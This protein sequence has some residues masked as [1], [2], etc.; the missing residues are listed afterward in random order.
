MTEEAAGLA[1]LHT[2]ELHRDNFERLVRERSN[3][4]RPLHRVEPALLA[5]AE[6]EG[7]EAPSVVA[8]TRQVVEAL[9]RQG[10]EL[11]VCTCSTLGAVVEALPPM[12]PCRTMR[13]DRPMAERATA[14][15]GRVLV[16]AAVASTRTPT[17]ALLADAA[18][19]QGS[20]VELIDGLCDEA[21][22]HFSRG[23]VSAYL[24]TLARF[25]RRRPPDVSAIVLAQASMADLPRLCA[26]IEVPFLSSPRS[27][28][29][30]AFALLEE[31]HNQAEA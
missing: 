18:A 23:R 11:V 12:G 17:H 30:A 1:F 27:G 3:M 26:D 13:I 9:A 31:R 2:A 8:E 24:A 7:P 25:V 4:V 5:R 10:A 15:D 22:S 14:R 19:R 16:V 28:V 6:A 29:E 21:W 20:R